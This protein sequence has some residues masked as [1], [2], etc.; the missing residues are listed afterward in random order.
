MKNWI[1]KTIMIIGLIHTI[2]GFLFIGHI[3]QEIWNAGL[4]NTVNGQIEWEFFFWFTMFGGLLM[5]LGG[6]VDWLEKKLSYIPQGLGWGL[7][8]FTTMM[9]LIMHMSVVLSDFSES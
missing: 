4:V 7:L 3:F 8:I 9:L 5:I 2:F 1:G 6:L